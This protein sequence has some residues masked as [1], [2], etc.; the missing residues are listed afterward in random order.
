MAE[1]TIQ[2]LIDIFNRSNGDQDP[3]EPTGDPSDVTFAA[4]GFDSLTT[5]NAVRRIERK[6]G[7]ELGEN[8]ISEAR[9]PR[10]LL[11]R[12]NAALAAA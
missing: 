12:V 8:V 4:L 2:D 5:L 11:D 3:V 10:Q 6:H 9:T 1:L 7:V